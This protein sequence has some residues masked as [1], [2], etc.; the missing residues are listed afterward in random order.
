MCLVAETRVQVPTPAPPSK[1]LGQIAQQREH[2]PSPAGKWDI[3]TRSEVK[4]DG[5]DGEWP[6]GVV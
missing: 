2:Q 1:V 3:Y 6:C 4:H 5:I